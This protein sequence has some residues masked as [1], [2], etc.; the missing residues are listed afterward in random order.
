MLLKNIFKLFSMFIFLFTGTP[1]EIV[2]TWTTYNFTGVGRDQMEESV[3]QFGE[4][5]GSDKLTQTATGSS[6]IFTDGG[7][8]RRQHRI[9]R[10]LLTGLKPFTVYR[11]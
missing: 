9:H 11:K 1:T 7:D 5:N 2:V 3:V 10:V 6:I 4:K 8:Q